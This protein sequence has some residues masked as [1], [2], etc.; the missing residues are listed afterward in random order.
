MVPVQFHFHRRHKDEL[1]D[2]KQYTQELR[3]SSKHLS[4]CSVAGRRVLL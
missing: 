2:L 1:K 3:L 4:A